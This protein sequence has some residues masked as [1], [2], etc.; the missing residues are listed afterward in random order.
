MAPQ[1]IASEGFAGDAAASQDVGHFPARAE[2][3]AQ[4]PVAAP[5]CPARWRGLRQD[6]GRLVRSR[7]PGCRRRSPPGPAVET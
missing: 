3:A 7:A 6:G 1:G 2:L 4:G 5:R